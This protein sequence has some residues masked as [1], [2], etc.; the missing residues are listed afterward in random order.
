MHIDRTTSQDAG[1]DPRADVVVATASLD[2]GFN[3]PEVGAVLQ[4]KAPRR[5]SQFLQRRGRAGRS[6]RMRPWTIV[7]LSDFGRDRVAYEAYDL[8]FDPELEPQPLPVDNRHVQRM[9]A[10]YCLLEWLEARMD[11]GD[12]CGRNSLAPHARGWSS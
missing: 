8:L 4:H 7:T 1:V 9:Q 3:D 2:V 12:P 11:G 6:R 5:S 10:T